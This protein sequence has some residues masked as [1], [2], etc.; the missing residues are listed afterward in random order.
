M[1]ELNKTA[2]NA[3]ENAK[4]RSNDC[5]LTVRRIIADAR[6]KRL[7]RALTRSTRRRREPY[8]ITVRLGDNTP[9]PLN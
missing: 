2:K 8:N 5:G 9:G 1:S 4:P 6:L 3:R 7:T